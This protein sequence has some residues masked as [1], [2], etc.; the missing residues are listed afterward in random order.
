MVKDVAAC[1][2]EWIG[3][4]SECGWMQKH[5]GTSPVSEGKVGLM[6]MSLVPTSSLDPVLQSETLL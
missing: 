3:L 4:A 1:T 5:L 2:G 6:V